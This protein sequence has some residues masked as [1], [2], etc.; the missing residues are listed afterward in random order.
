MF[1][2]S[3]LG[4]CGRMLFLF[5]LLINLTNISYMNQRWPPFLIFIKYNIISKTRT[6]YSHIKK[7]KSATDGLSQLM[8][9]GQTDR[10][11]YVMDVARLI[12]DFFVI[13]IYAHVYMREGQFGKITCTNTCHHIHNQNH[14]K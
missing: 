13:E 6:K 14:A 10:Q 12:T 5:C 4:N 2:L 11:T 7:T 1:D 8:L 9:S 3:L